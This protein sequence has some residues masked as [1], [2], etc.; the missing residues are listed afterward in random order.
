MEQGVG[1]VCHEIYATLLAESLEPEGTGE[2]GPLHHD[3]YA[4]VPVTA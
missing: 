3:I 1:P 2:D 4:D